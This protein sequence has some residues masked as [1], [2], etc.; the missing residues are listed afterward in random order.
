MQDYLAYA[1]VVHIGL[2]LVRPGDGEKFVYSPVNANATLHCAVNNTFL[3][4]SVDGLN[5]DNDNKRSILFSRGIFQSTN[6]VG[7]LIQ[8]TL[9]VD[10]EKE[11]NNNIEICCEYLEEER[12]R[13]SCTTLVIYGM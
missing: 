7:A 8:S 4:W 5:F 11:L 3:S 9:T 10:G 12:Q 1:G 6:T 2:F 13:D